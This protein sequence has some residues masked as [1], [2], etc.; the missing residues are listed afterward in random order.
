M[1]VAAVVIQLRIAV[2]SHCGDAMK[3]RGLRFT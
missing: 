2:A 3:K 1:A